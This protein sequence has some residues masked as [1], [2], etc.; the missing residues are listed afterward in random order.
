MI[1]IN[2]GDVIGCADAV[3]CDVEAA[4]ALSLTVCIYAGETARE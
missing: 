4:S 1:D 2:Q 3:S